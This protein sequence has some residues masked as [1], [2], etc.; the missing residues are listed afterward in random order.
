MGPFIDSLH[1][2]RC[3][4]HPDHIVITKILPDAWEIGDE[5]SP[6]TPLIL[7]EVR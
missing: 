6:P 3:C 4:G 2:L 5:A 7:G 1:A